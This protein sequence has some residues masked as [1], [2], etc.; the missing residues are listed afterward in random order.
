MNKTRDDKL[1]YFGDHVSFRCEN[2]RP[3]EWEHPSIY[4]SLNR[5]IITPCKG[6]FPATLC[7]QNPLQR[8]DNAQAIS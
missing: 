8:I 7:H 6:T 1:H 5:F 3:N 4:L 2:I